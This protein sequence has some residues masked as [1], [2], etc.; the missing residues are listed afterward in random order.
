M[1]VD[2]DL[3]NDLNYLKLYLE[4]GN[5]DY[6]VLI[7]Y[8]INDP[9]LRDYIIGLI[10]DNA[11]G[12]NITCEDC[13]EDSSINLTSTWSS[14]KISDE[15][16]KNIIYDLNTIPDVRITNGVAP[17]RSLLQ[18]VY[19]GDSSYWKDN[20][21]K[22]I[23]IESD[24]AILRQKRVYNLDGDFWGITY[25]KYEKTDEA[26]IR[27]GIL[28]E[29]GPDADILDWNDL[30]EYYNKYGNLEVLEFLKFDY[31]DR[32]YGVVTRDGELLYSSSRGYFILEEGKY[33]QSSFLV[34]DSIGSGQGE[35]GGNVLDL[36]SWDGPGRVLVKI[37]PKKDTDLID[38]ENTSTENTW[39]SAKISTEIS[40]NKIYTLSNI[41]DVNI[42]NYIANDGD[43][44]QWKTDGDS[45][46]WVNVDIS[47]ALGQ[48]S[49]SNSLKMEDLIDVEYEGSQPNSY[50]VLVSMPVPTEEYSAEEEIIWQDVSLRTVFETYKTVILNDNYESGTS[51]TWSINKWKE[52]IS[53]EINNAT[54]NID[55]E[56][57][58]AILYSDYTNNVVIRYVDWTNDPEQ[59]EIRKFLRLSETG[60]GNYI[61]GEFTDGDVTAYGR[62][63]PDGTTEF[64]SELKTESLGDD[65]DY[66]DPNKTIIKTKRIIIQSK[67]M[68]YFE[69]NVVVQ[70]GTIETLG[71][72]DNYQYNLNLIENDSLLGDKDNLVIN[73]YTGEVLDPTAT[74]ENITA[75]GDKSLV[76]KEYVD[77]SITSLSSGGGVEIYQ[78]LPT[79]TLDTFKQ[80][81]YEID[82]GNTFICV[83]DT[84]DP[85]SDDD[86]FWVQL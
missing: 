5:I 69:V 21:P 31:L 15:I 84:T 37:K 59:A 46:S 29:F 27:A 67:I 28:D 49:Q 82:S 62:I 32:N 26:A 1:A 6:D 75:R 25:N 76:T 60:S 65:L 53:N 14:S 12:S 47:T 72:I 11:G 3:V 16:E 71:D 83:A 10:T 43:I 33:F 61:I 56:T 48:L 52:Y 13:F 36:G 17:D 78:T 20:S 73:M 4:K 40:S 45:A 70:E 51:V 9:S 44:L 2:F 19:D 86:C 50:S 30:K 66:D 38:D 42:E 8:L 79:A 55:I 58:P 41:P 39:S 85:Q 18:Y 35:H 24:N 34:H 80:I 22:N 81:S 57:Y 7:N 63:L 54:D 68:D 77:S 23:A 74:I 64:Y